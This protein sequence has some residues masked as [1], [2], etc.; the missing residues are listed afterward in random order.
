VIVLFARLDVVFETAAVPALVAFDDVDMGF[1][2][3]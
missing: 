1:V 2:A 3:E